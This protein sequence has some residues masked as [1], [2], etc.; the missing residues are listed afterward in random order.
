[1]SLHGWKV[2][3]F[4]L[5]N[6]PSSRRTRTSLTHK[7]RTSSSPL[8]PSWDFRDITE[9]NGRA[10]LPTFRQEGGSSAHGAATCLHPGPGCHS[11]EG[12]LPCQGPA[13][14]PSTSVFPACE[15]TLLR[16]DVSRRLHTAHPR[17][18]PSPPPAERTPTTAPLSGAQRPP[19]PTAAAPRAPCSGSAVRLTVAPR[20]R[21]QGEA[22]TDG[23]AKPRLAES[24]LTRT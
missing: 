1:M 17:C 5:S 24:R 19:A 16:E 8:S 3:S 4:E 14:P 9:V 23:E 21:F 6:I 22:P 12:G 11:T 15:D 2:V 20:P 13:A 7:V 10:A 18:P